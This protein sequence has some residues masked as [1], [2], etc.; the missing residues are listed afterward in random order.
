[1]NASQGQQRGLRSAAIFML[2]AGGI[3]C[4]I[5]VLVGGAMGLSPASL[6]ALSFGGSAWAMSEVGVSR[7][8]GWLAGVFGMLAAVLA[9]WR[10]ASR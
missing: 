4:A 1:M 5:D 10:A 6:S 7:R 8:V 9:I 2:L 3:T